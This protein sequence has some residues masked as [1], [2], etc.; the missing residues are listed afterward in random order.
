MPY[1]FLLDSGLGPVSGAAWPLPADGG[2]G[3]WLEAAAIQPPGSRVQAYAAADL[4]FWI[5]QVLWEVEL[6]GNVTEHDC[7]L[8]ADRGRLL[9][10]VQRW[11]PDVS[12]SF[13]AA[14]GLRTRSHVVE[15]LRHDGYEAQ[16]QRL[17]ACPDLAAIAAMGAEVASELEDRSRLFAS[18]AAANALAAAAPRTGITA[19]LTAVVAGEVARATGA[20]AEFDEGFLAER[21]WQAGWL[22]EQLELPVGVG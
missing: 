6:D 12:A 18:R 7:Y 5:S 4:P 9:R 8:A 22:A 17:A 19:H 15:L 3:A 21:R 11:T 10:Q 13:A 2:P 16:A 20:T 1:V 14:C